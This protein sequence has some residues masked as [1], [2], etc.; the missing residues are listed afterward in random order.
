MSGPDEARVAKRGPALAEQPSDLPQG[1]W[2][3]PS[4][5]VVGTAHRGH[6]VTGHTGRQP[7]T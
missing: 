3:A 6:S 1:W 5:G 7:L 2:G 4:A